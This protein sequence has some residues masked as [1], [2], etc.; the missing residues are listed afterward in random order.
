MSPLLGV[1]SETFLITDGNLAPKPVCWS[2][3]D[4]KQSWLERGAAAFETLHGAARPGVTWAMSNAPFDAAVGGGRDRALLLA[5]F[6][7]LERGEI[8]DV[9]VAA[10][11]DAIAEGR[12]TE[13]M[14]LDRDGAPLRRY[15]DHGP[16]TNRI[17]LDNAVWLYLGRRNAKENDEYRLRYGELADLPEDQWPESA[18]Q[19]PLDDARNQ[20]DVAVVQRQ[21]CKNIGPIGVAL[22]DL[23]P[24]IRHSHLTHQ[25][26]AH[27][28]M[29]LGSVWGLRTDPVRIAELEAE[30]AKVRAAGDAKF[31]ALGFVKTRPV[32]HT[33]TGTRKDDDGKDDI[34]EVKRRVVVA[35]GGSLEAKC[36]ECHG[37]TK[38]KSAKSGSQV[39]CKACNATGLEVP[40]QVPRTPAGGICGDRDILKDS[41]DEDLIAWAAY[42]ELDK[43]EQTYIPVL[44]LGVGKPWC[45]RSNVLVSTARSSY[46]G[47][48]Q[49]LPPMAREAIIAPPMFTEIDVPDDYQLQPG[50]EWVE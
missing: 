26:R 11:L 25:T 35:Y 49:L 33:R 3:A 21:V 2:F 39:N 43:L 6:E 5:W 23:L 7:K 48:I 12:M 22:E 30:V 1:D 37:T 10:T 18:R 34:A 38:T 28:I 46:E 40:P 17:K 31:R 27:M 9:E 13:G 45:I 4:E 24:T 29:H 32:E 50:E 16:A 14:I 47:V 19:Y 15:G 44:K 42:G 41:A 20:Y 36:P 8:H